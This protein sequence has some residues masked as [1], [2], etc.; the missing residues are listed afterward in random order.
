MFAYVLKDK[1]EQNEKNYNYT[2]LVENNRGREEIRESY[3]ITKIEWLQEK[4]KW[5]NLTSIGLL[6]TTF[7]QNDK[8]KIVLRYYISSKELTAAQLIYY[9]RNE[10]KIESM[11][12]LLDVNLKEELTKLSEQN[13]QES[14]NILRKISL[15]SMKLYK[16]IALKML[17]V[18]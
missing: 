17:S 3:V 15:N 11:H 10:W 1:V 9:A 18:D 12:W 6:K 13:A 8:E 5:R 14:L 16:Q 7:I 2:K 4:D